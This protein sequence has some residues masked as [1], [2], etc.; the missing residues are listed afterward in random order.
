METGLLSALFAAV[1][2]IQ[3]MYSQELRMYTLLPLTAVLSF[4]FLLRFL[5]DDRNSFL[6]G[7]IISLTAWHP[8]NQDKAVLLRNPQ[9]LE[10][11]ASDLIEDIRKGLTAQS[12]LFILFVPDKVNEFLYRQVMETFG[13]SRIKTAAKFRQS[14]IWTPVLVLIIQNEGSVKGLS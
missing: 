6:I 11:E 3:V 7:Y 14:L 5:S 2:P 1:F 13:E 4:Y 12:R 10:T 8:A 9:K